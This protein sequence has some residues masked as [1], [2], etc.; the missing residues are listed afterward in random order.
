MASKTNP[1]SNYYWKRIETAPK[2]KFPFILADFRRDALSLGLDKIIQTLQTVESYM[3]EN[4][5]LSQINIL[6]EQKLQEKYSTISGDYFG[7]YDP[8]KDIILVKNG[9]LL[10]VLSIGFHECAERE[11]RQVPVLK[12]IT[13]Y[14]GVY[15]DDN[16]LSDPQVHSFIHNLS[17]ELQILIT[18]KFEKSPGPKGELRK[19]TKEL[20]IE[21]I[22]SNEPKDPILIDR[23]KSYCKT[24]QETYL[25]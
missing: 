1:F 8:K 16:T 3:S 24:Q 18:E 14:L 17:L 4:P 6:P 15:F 12:Q 10:Q 23:L 20:V 25:I 19:K 7:F 9:P 22:N 11:L 5:D 2:L 21:M 13:D